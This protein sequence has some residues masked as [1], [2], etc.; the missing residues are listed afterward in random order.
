MHTPR[1]MSRRLFLAQS[2]VV[3]LAAAACGSD[4]SSVDGD[5]T[6]GAPTTAPADATTA[7]PSTSGP[8]PAG[9]FPV[10]IE[11][12]FGTTT[13]DA[14]PERVVTIGDFAELDNLVALGVTPVA[15]G[16]TNSW[17][18]GLTPW[19]ADAGIDSFDR[20][21]VATEVPLEAVAAR[22]PDLILAM[23]W[24]AGDQI[25]E[26]TAIA[27]VVGLGWDVTWRDA[28]HQVAAATGTSARADELQADVEAAIAA[29]KEQLAGN[30]A[31]TI[32]IG[33][34]YG[35][36]LYLQGAQS[37][38]TV[39]LTE[40]GLTVVPG[41]EPVLT[42]L[43]LEQVPQ[44]GDADVL[45]SLATDPAATSIA[46]ASPLWTAL[47]AVQAGRYSAIEPT[48]ARAMADGFNALSYAWAL[49][50]VVELLTET[51]AGR[52]LPQD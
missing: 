10:T 48:L 49:P 24:P 7:D 6:T 18:T 12:F 11:H 1:P 2:A 33:S 15:F 36:V 25:D 27:P 5:S 50:R 20:F 17:A 16:F 13:L 34:F 35:D 14:A 42:E 26:L 40:L 4:D 21:D 51:F 8:V 44:L 32:K 30:E 29:A 47:P 39:L 45:L 37:P 19:Q 31:L 41:P 22:R 46:E 28:L 3:V 52:G 38:I 9:E 43:S 23:P